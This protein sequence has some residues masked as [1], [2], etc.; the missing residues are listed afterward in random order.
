LVLANAGT[1]DAIPPLP[2]GKQLKLSP[3][4][5]AALDELNFKQVSSP[6]AQ[7]ACECA[8]KASRRIDF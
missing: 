1:W 3:S 8:L 5:L 2:D 7:M 4:T 6:A